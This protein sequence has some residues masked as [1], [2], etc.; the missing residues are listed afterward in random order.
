MAHDRVLELTTENFDR[1]VKDLKNG[2]LLVD[3]WADWCHPC[4]MLEPH[5]KRLVEE[6]DRV[7]LGKLNTDEHPEVAAR[8]GVMSIPTLIFFR[9]G[10]ELDRLIGAVP[11]HVLKA[12]VE[13]LL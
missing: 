8:F 13:E 4:K 5:L 6:Y 11:Y 2:I 10:Q 7:T 9:G 1:V 12:K 3:F